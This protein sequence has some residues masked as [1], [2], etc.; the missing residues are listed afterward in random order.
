MPHR[1]ATHRLSAADSLLWRIEADPVLRSPILVVGL[2]DRS[3]TTDGLEAMIERAATV[4]PRLR[5]RITAPPW[6]VGRPRWEDDDG[7]LAHH[8]RRVRAPGGDLDAVLAVAQPD[9]AA[10]FDPARP[11]W[12]LTIVD[13]LDEGRAAVVLRFHHALTDGVGGIELADLLFDRARRPPRS[14]LAAGDGAAAPPPSRHIDPATLVAGATD[15]ARR[16]LEAATHPLPTLNAGIRLG[17]SAGRMLAPAPPGSPELSQR[18]LD[19][20][21]AVTECPL[22]AVRRAASATDGTINDVL[23]AAVAGALAAYH[24]AQGRPVPGVRVTMPISIRRPDDRIGGNRFVPARF[25]L[26][27]DDPDPRARVRIAGDIARR[28]RGE[29]ALGATDVLAAGLNLLPRPV[30]SRLFGG[31]LRSIDVDVAN[32]PGLDRPAFVGGARLLRLWAFAP[33]TGAALSVTLVSHERTCC[34]GLACDRRA[35]ADPEL[36]GVCLDAALSEVVG[37]GTAHRVAA[38]G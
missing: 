23:L 1:P 7:S 2:L 11:P 14:L 9:A 17:R 18:S 31:M 21:L 38:T 27:I 25:T 28:W 32:V 36:L 15:A 26:P 35:V 30:V 29:A 3:P 5:Q 34:V 6:G 16:L 37:L 10:A 12:T 33:P 19:R 22:A 13:G 4:L 20:W 8:V 24:R